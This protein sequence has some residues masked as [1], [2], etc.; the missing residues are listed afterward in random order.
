[1]DLQFP[2]FS[3]VVSDKRQK[4]QRPQILGDSNRSCLRGTPPEVSGNIS[5]LNN[6]LKGGCVAI[7]IRTHFNEHWPS[8]S[9]P[10]S[11][12]RFDKVWTFGLKSVFGRTPDPTWGPRVQW[13]FTQNRGPVWS[14]RQANRASVCF[15]HCTNN[16][17]HAKPDTRHTAS[18]AERSSRDL[19]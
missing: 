11:E 9:H 12:L 13:M 8:S 19:S 2:N 15:S 4:T 17:T 1:M 6:P 10:A 14:P 5:F 16:G 18:C 3:S 7:S